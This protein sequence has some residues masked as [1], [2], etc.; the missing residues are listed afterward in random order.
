MCINSRVCLC[1]VRTGCRAVCPGTV[2]SDS[3]TETWAA[4]CSTTRCWREPGSSWRASCSRRVHA[5]SL[6]SKVTS[7]GG[8]DRLTVKPCISPPAAVLMVMLFCSVWSCILT[9][10]LDFL[11]RGRHRGGAERHWGSD[12]LQTSRRLP[13]LVPHPQRTETGD[14]GVGIS[15]KSLLQSACLSL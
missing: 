13:L 6:R 10:M 14:P 2:C 11:L 12:R 4:T 7:R 8:E 9:V 15:L 5:W 1:S 3:T